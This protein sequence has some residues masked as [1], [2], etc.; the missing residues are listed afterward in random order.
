MVIKECCNV[1][2]GDSM[3]LTVLLMSLVIPQNFKAFRLMLKTSI[4]L[5]AG[6]VLSYSEWEILALTAK[7]LGPAEVVA[8][9]LLGTLWDVIEYI[10]VSVA[11]AAEVRV[12]MLLGSGRPERAKLS[13]YKSTFL[14]VFISMI[15]S[16]ILFIIGDDAPTWMTDDATLQSMLR[17]LIPLFGV[18]NIALSVG[19][20]SWSLVGAQGRYRLSTS[21]GLLGSWL[22]TVPLSVVCTVWLK[23]D[24]QGQTAAV[25]IGYMASG[26]V[27]TYLLFT[28]DW[29]N[30]SKEVIAAHHDDN[31]DSSSSSSRGDSTAG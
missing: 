1:S 27:N 21:V 22:V 30:L 15:V 11:D 10:T 20:M 28:S 31:P 19:T 24:L 13:A 2:I 4:A 9:G 5:S 14:A 23:V 8:W 7:S 26:T 29:E 12:A 6:H 16:S 18:G 25:V 17:D 3:H